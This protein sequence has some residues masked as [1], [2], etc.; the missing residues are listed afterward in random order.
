MSTSSPQDP[1]VSPVIGTM[2]LIALTVIFVAVVVAVVMGISGGMFAFKSVGMTLDPYGIGG[3]NPEHGIGITI[4]GG[5]DA[6]DI[7]SLSAVIT[8]PK[9]IYAP[10]NASYVDNPQ[11]G[12][13]YRFAAYVDPKIIEAINR[14][15]Y[16]V[17]L[18]T[19]G[20]IQVAALDCYV[21]VTGKFRDGTEQVLLVRHVIIPAIPGTEGGISGEYVSVVPYFINET[22]PAHGFIIT[23]LNKSVTSLGKMATFQIS[24]PKVDSVTVEGTAQKDNRS[25]TYDLSTK[26]D[27]SGD[28]WDKTPYPEIT[29]KHWMLGQLIGNVTVSLVGDGVPSEVTVGPITIPPRKNIFENQNYLAG[30]IIYDKVSENV[31]LSLTTQNLP[32]TQTPNLAYYFIQS[33]KPVMED[34]LSGMRGENLSLEVGTLERHR[35]Q[36][37]EAYVKVHV[38]PTEVWYR[39]ASVSVANLIR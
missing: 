26:L 20:K 4:Y 21:T 24:S 12:Q 32:R 22:Y 27:K 3:E 38:D 10:T 2:L 30:S 23:I 35:G 16:H 9:L 17:N 39:V 1:A 33:E 29:G 28:G 25:S 18:T 19:D 11:T 31:S 7:V 6:A 13:E 36:T 34:S 8:G 5:A 15:N 14:K 37:L